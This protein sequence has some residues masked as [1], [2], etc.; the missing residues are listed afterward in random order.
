MKF[1]D[2]L[3]QFFLIIAI[4]GGILFFVGL[5]TRNKLPDKNVSLPQL[6]N[7]PTQTPTDAKP[8]RIIKGD[9][10]Y[11]I[12]PLYDYDFYG[13]IVSVGDNRVWYSRFKESDPLNSNDICAVWGK[14]IDS[15]IY[16]KMKF[17]NE[18]FMCQAEFRGTSQ[19]FSLFSNEQVANNHLL[20]DDKKNPELFELIRSAKIGDQ[21]HFKGYL[22]TYNIFKNNQLISSRGT[23]T[24]RTD[25]GN[26]ACEVVYATSFEILKSNLSV[27]YMLYAGG[28]YLSIFSALAWAILFIASLI[29]PS[30]PKII[31]EKPPETIDTFGQ[32]LPTNLSEEIK[33]KRQK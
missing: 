24:T 23:S 17:K 12:N 20:T 1:L 30:E 19:E 21:I 18:E 33:E 15:G 7:D 13:M 9:L 27:Y 4:A 22:A 8:F 2:K 14:N 16:Q 28:K 10:T 29:W 11:E 6:K 31:A 5:L 26:G 25:Q 3:E 32:M